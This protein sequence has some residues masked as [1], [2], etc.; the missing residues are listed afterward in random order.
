MAQ[1][2][3]NHRP[4]RGSF[5][6]SHRP[7]EWL[8]LGLIL[9]RCVDHDRPEVDMRDSYDGQEGYRKERSRCRQPAYR[10]GRHT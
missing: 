4:Q 9:A 3:A 6:G 2:W 5:S 1:Y 7:T 10:F 8:S